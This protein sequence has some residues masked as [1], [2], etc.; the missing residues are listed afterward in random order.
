MT[1]WSDFH[2]RGRAQP[3]RGR[4]IVTAWAVEYRA[5][6]CATLP[7]RHARGV[8]ASERGQHGDLG[9][10]TPDDVIMAL[11]GRAARTQRPHRLFA[12]LQDRA[13]RHHGGGRLAL[14]RAAD[15]VL[16]CRQHARPARTSGA[17]D[18]DRCSRRS[19]MRSRSRSWK[20]AASPR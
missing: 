10:I 14:A 9:M 1:G 18:L 16:R 19:A 7:R 12:P 11:R 13:D 5:Q 8:R 6:I 3:A 15:V 2:R 20:T 17:D 4:V